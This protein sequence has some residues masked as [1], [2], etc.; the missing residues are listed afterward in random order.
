MSF[1][2]A[3]YDPHDTIAA[4]ASAAGGAYRGIVRVGGPATGEVLRECFRAEGNAAFPT[5][6]P[7]VLLRGEL[8]CEPPIGPLPC[9]LYWWPTAKSYT[10]QPLAEIHTL[11]SPPLLHA[12]LQA[13]C[14]AGARTAGRGE[15]T[16]RAFFSGRLDLVQ[17]EAVL[18]VIEA[19][20][21]DQLA[22]ALVQLAGGLS[23]PLAQLRDDLLNLLADLEAGLDFVEDEIE[24]I[25]R[26][27]LTNRLA[28]ADETIARLLAQMAART[29]T[30]DL[31]RVA[32]YGWPNVGKSSLLNA[33]TREEA[34][35]VSPL[36]GTTR[37]YV[38]REVTLAWQRFKLIDTAG[39]A[40]TAAGEG[41]A[42]IE[43]AAQTLGGE[44]LRQ[45][46]LRVLCLDSSRPLNAWELA[47]LA[48]ADAQRIVVL[49]KCDQP[50]AIEPAGA[51]G[52]SAEDGS[53]LEEL[54]STLALRLAESQIAAEGMVAGTAM[55]CEG[56]LRLAHDS[57]QRAL[58]LAAADAL[59]SGGEELIA[60]ELRTALAELARV[61][62]AVYTDD[63]LDRIFSR[64]C[65]GK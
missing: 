8:I 37:D 58:A 50:A 11:G 46:E 59:A 14:A 63:V 5:G 35:I 3:S 6:G 51:I 20:G 60:A 44:A 54:A 56:S 64:F 13:A 15:F 43:A 53:G 27:D 30:A 52:T 19:E 26:D 57:L 1:H 12:V 45:A 18:G 7:A 25:S 62:G 34:A 10:G 41:I 40:A 24:F 49:T 36:E 23:G 55:R 9:T 48:E 38:T 31:P 21:H 22:T 29:D 28:A 61:V 39:F 4:I 17:A 2:P 47:R 16:L 33:L 32:L 65:I 42:A